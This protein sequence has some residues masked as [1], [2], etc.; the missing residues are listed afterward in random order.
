MVSPHSAARQI[1]GLSVGLRRVPGS[2][3]VRAVGCT[4]S[5]NGARVVVF[6]WVAA[7]CD[8][9]TFRAPV[10][11]ASILLLRESSAPLIAS[12][13]LRIKETASLIVFTLYGFEIGKIVRISAGDMLPLSGAFGWRR[14][15]AGV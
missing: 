14:L 3:G 7:V 6:A 15:C 1:A 9:A 8:A 10:S 12:S 5:G 11:T 4:L 2:V 13:L